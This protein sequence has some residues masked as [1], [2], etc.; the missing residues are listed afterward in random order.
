MHPIETLRVYLLMSFQAAPL[1]FAGFTGMLSLGLSNL[2]MFMLFIAQVI[3]VPLV[4]AILQFAHG[5]ILGDTNS[6]VSVSASDICQLV[7][8]I[9]AAGT[10]SIV[11]PSIWVT[12]IML[13]MTYLFYNAL[14]I[15]NMPAESGADETKVANRKA[16]ATSTMIIVAVTAASLVGLRLYLG[17]GCETIYGAGLAVF[18]GT[19]LGIGWYELAKVCGVRHA[20]VFGIVAKMLPP[21][22]MEPPPKMCVYNGPT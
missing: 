22:A 13:F 7:P 18:L 19:G 5:L 6:L 1:L 17:K 10:R 11:A 20:D 16:R 12:Q 9:P 2:G 3:V 21:G 14:S 4:V 8:I 15:Y